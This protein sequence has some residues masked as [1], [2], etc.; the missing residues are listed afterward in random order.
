MASPDD[1]EPMPRNVPPSRKR[2]EERN[3]MISVRLT[4]SLRQVLDDFRKEAALSYPDII[5]AGLKAAAGE[6]EASKEAW[7][8]AEHKYMI[9]IPCSVCGKP[10][11]MKPGSDMHKAAIDLLRAKKWCHSECLKKPD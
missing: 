1:L 7:D 2:Y 11:I 6:W 5:K 8:D 9:A 3:P 4:K 10:M